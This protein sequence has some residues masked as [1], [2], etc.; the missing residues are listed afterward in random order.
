MKAANRTGDKDIINCMR[1]SLSARYGEKL[2]G[3]GGVLLLEKGKANIH[4]VVLRFVPHEKLVSFP[5]S[6]VV[7]TLHT[8]TVHTICTIAY[9]CKNIP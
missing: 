6:T 2:M 9:T 8:T 5:R 4:I 1:T 3:L 7:T